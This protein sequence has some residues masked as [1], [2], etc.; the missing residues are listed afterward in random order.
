MNYIEYFASLKGKKITVVG[1]G[2]SNRP[3]VKMLAESGALV[4]VR[5][6]NEIPE[7]VRAEFE[8]VEFVTGADYLCDL[9]DELIFKTPGMR[10]D[11]PEFLAA[12]KNGSKITS[13]MQLFFELCPCR[14]IAVTGSEGKTTTTTLIYN[15]LK[16]QGHTVFLGG[17]IGTPLLPRISQMKENDIVIAELSSF[18]LFDM[19]VSADTAVITNIVEEHLNW[20]TS[21]EEYIEAKKT[22]FRHQGENGRLILNADYETTLSLAPEANGKTEL[23]SRKS[24]V[25]NGA[26]LNEN[27]FIV[28]KDE[29]GSVTIFHKDSIK[30]PGDHN[31][32]NFMAAICATWGLASISTYRKIA[33]EFGGVEH[34]MEFVREKD[35]V[36]YYNDS[37]ATSPTSVIACLKSQTQKIITISGGSD[38]NLNYADV[39]PYII[40]HV[41]HMILTGQTAQ[42]IYKAVTE[43]EGYD[44]AVTVLEFADGMADAVEKAHACAKEGDIVYLSPISASFDC[45][46]NFEERGKHFKDLVNKL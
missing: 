31:V 46:K 29:S 9:T 33:K 39:A 10:R 32:E 19:T 16:E 43:C 37:I 5:D 24:P 36:K 1:F 27:G 2:V 26:F 34:R 13:E 7:I 22:V 18:Q 6:K 44:P 30:I 25:E 20:H 23:F 38:K 41:K 3:F 40:K 12:E 45:Y 14:I 21:M 35:G 4:T 17:N 8:N 15:I 42:K 28:H 11:I